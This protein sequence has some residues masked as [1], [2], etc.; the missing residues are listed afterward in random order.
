MNI[1]RYNEIVEN[2]KLAVA[3]LQAHKEAHSAEHSQTT[4]TAVKYWHEQEL[5]LRRL[6]AKYKHLESKDNG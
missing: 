1:D 4:Y 6:L 3:A 5:S 2:H